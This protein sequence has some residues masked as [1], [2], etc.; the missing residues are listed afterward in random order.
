[1]IKTKNVVARAAVAR[2]PNTPPE[3]LAK[4]AEDEYWDIRQA[5]AENPNTPPEVLAKYKKK[6]FSALRD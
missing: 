1:M 6:D 4:L 5:V 3:V 2:N